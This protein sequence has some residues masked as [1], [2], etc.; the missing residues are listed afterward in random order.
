[1]MN[2]ESLLTDTLRFAYRFFLTVST[3]IFHPKSFVSQVRQKDENEFLNEHSFFALCVLLYAGV[4]FNLDVHL[5]EF[6]NNLIAPSLGEKILYMLP[7][8]IFV[9]I[10]I[11]GTS[12]LLN[13][14]KELTDLFRS[15]SLY[16]WGA[17]IFLSVLIIL[18]LFFSFDESNTE[19]DADF[20]NIYFFSL[21]PVSILFLVQSCRSIFS[22]Q[23]GSILKRKFLLVSL[24]AAAASFASIFFVWFEEWVVAS[25]TK[26]PPKLSLAIHNFGKSLNDKSST[27]LYIDTVRTNDTTARVSYYL[28]NE[29][30]S[31]IF[32]NAKKG[33]SISLNDSNVLTFQFL[34]T[35]PKLPL[36]NIKPGELQVMSARSSKSSNELRELFDPGQKYQVVLHYSTDHSFE[37]KAIQ[38]PMDIQLQ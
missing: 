16:W 11:F 32:I 8:G 6:F 10:L 37:D 38:F 3:I 24:F 1:M 4:L 33:T 21:I 12:V 28:R 25:V 13:L 36:I 20:S 30:S 23:T 27:V 26:A 29:T 35:D 5:T 14:P 15:V 17:S 18:I 22:I 2:I 34:F 31:S 19:T 7:L 9:Y